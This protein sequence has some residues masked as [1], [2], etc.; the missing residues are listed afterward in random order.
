M[1]SKKC[2]PHDMRVAAKNIMLLYRDYQAAK[3]RFIVAVDEY[4]RYPQKARMTAFTIEQMEGESPV[5]Y[6]DVSRIRNRITGIVRINK[7]TREEAI[8][9]MAHG[10]IWN[11]KLM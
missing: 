11:K 4:G 6:K 8:K 1:S 2:D 9:M 3:L 5:T 7:T 10:E